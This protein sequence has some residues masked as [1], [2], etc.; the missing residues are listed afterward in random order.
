MALET[1]KQTRL[2][3]MEQITRERQKYQDLTEADPSTFKVHRMQ[4]SLR[5][6]RIKKDELDNI[7][8]AISAYA[9]EIDEAEEAKIQQSFNDNAEDLIAELIEIQK[10]HSG[11]KDLRGDIASLIKHQDEQPDKHHNIILSRITKALERVRTNL[12]EAALTIDNSYHTDLQQLQDLF[13]TRAATSPGIPKEE[14]SSSHAEP[15]PPWKRKM[16]H[17]KLA[18]PKFNGDIL[19][20]DA[21]WTRFKANID[22]DPF[23][24]EVDKLC[25]LQ[26]AIEDPAIDSTL[27]N[28]VKN[29]CH[30]SEVVR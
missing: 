6:V 28:G 2:V 26:E 14:S 22:S 9:D 21:F 24:T 8:A 12:N 13:L 20:W 30:Y 16:A 1:L 10:I 4:E 29:E 25:Y 7:Q 15:E 18:V 3:Q 23:Y 19:Q 5:K 17:L 27:F 11:I